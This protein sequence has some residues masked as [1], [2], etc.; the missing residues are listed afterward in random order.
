MHFLPIFITLVLY[1]TV[2]AVPKPSTADMLTMLTKRTENIKESGMA[3][4][5]E[6]NTW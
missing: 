1:N 4:P 2:D 3:S 5:T 6:I